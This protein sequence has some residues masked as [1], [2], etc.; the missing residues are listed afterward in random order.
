MSG[1]LF[2]ED[3][4]HELIAKEAELK[5]IKDRAKAYEESCKMQRE[6]WLDLLRR[7]IGWQD[8]TLSAVNEGLCAVRVIMG[9]AP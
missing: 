2:F 9:R 1:L 8:A 7:G 6:V 4:M 3:T 5:A